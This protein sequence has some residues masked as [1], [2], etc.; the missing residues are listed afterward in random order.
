MPLSRS[1]VAPSLAVVAVLALAGCGAG[2]DDAAPAEEETAESAQGVPEP[3]LEGVPEVVAVVNGEEIG[4]EEFTSAYEGQLQQAA[5]MQQQTGQEVDQDELKV[6]V[7]DLLVNNLLLT[8]AA[9]DAGIEASDE[10]IEGVLQNVADQS[11]LA[12]IDE[13]YAAFDD[14]GVPE[15]EVREN[16]ADQFRVEEF[17]AQEADISEPSDEEL[18]AQYDAL[19]EQTQGSEGGEGEEAEMPSFEEMRD[20]LAQ[21]ATMQEQNAAIEQIVTDLRESDDAEIEINL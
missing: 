18:R 14:Q 11:G 20:Q 13:V 16:A 12:S 5:M 2:S 17:V 9:A 8:Q 7:A 6:Q 15:D 4:L 21:Q 10:D 1:L 3:D 19:V